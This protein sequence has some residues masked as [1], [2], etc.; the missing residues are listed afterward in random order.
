MHVKQIMMNQS[1]ALRK[2]QQAELEVLL[3]VASF[4][5]KHDITWYLEGGTLLGAM[6]HQGFIP[7]DDDVDIAMLR[8]DYDRFLELAQEGL[9]DGYSLH[10]PQ[11][12]P[13]QAALFAKVFKD[14]TRFVNQES[15]DAG[16]DQGIFI[17]VFPYDRLPVDSRKRKKMVSSASLAQRLSYLYA[18][19]ATVVPHKGAL[20]AAER[21]AC[22][23][24]HHLICLLPGDG[25]R[26]A[27]QFDRACSSCAVEELSEEVLTLVW[28]EMMPYPIADLVPV[29]TASFEGYELPVP[30]KPEHY[31]QNMYGNWQELPAPEDR[32]THLPLLLDFGDGTVWE[33]GKDDA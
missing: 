15:L 3:T 25:T 9:P 18:S 8:E 13:G 19:G 29:S 26:F 22:G 10:T 20:G 7:W 27:L 23:L 31:L 16:F 2:L 32:H 6:R 17:D 14:G 33:A 11:N 1:D 5:Q 24:A 21:F 28:P 12:T 30:A 4:C